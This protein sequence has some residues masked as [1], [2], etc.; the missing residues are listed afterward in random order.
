MKTQNSSRSFVCNKLDL[1]KLWSV[2]E[3]IFV[4]TKISDGGILSPKWYLNV[5][6]TK[7]HLFFS[8]LRFDH[9]LLSLEDMGDCSCCQILGW[10][11]NDFWLL[12]CTW[13]FSVW[14]LSDSKNFLSRR[15]LRLNACFNDDHL[16]IQGGKVPAVYQNAVESRLGGFITEKSSSVNYCSRG[17]S[18]QSL[19]WARVKQVNWKQEAREHVSNS[20]EVW[21]SQV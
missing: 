7:G 2:C 4:R 8:P 19:I 9:H 6:P 21:H 12:L 11:G 14:S 20:A 3:F 17:T 18:S 1:Q 16:G 10:W 13:L 15:Q 5:L